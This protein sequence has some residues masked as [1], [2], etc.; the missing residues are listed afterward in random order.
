MFHIEVQNSEGELVFQHRWGCFPS[1]KQIIETLQESIFFRH[2]KMLA[3]TI[4]L[5][6]DD[7]DVNHAA[8][9]DSLT[10]F[11]VFKINHQE[12]ESREQWQQFACSA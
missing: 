2:I 10:G 12:G 4:Q 7:D 5:L 1:D 11:Q 8:T 9:G 3:A 6:R